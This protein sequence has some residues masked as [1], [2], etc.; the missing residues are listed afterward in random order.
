MHIASIIETNLLKFDRHL[1]VCLVWTVVMTQPSS[2]IALNDCPPAGK[3]IHLQPLP[4]DLIMFNSV[5]R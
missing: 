1:A 3:L 4:F 2:K 5:V